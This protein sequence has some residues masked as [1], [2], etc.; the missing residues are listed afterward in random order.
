MYLK[1]LRI[2]SEQPSFGSME[3]PVLDIN[4]VS[5]KT[6]RKR[7]WSGSHMHRSGTQRSICFTYLY[8]WYILKYLDYYDI[9]MIHEVD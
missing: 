7:G 5:K 6:K 9:M 2:S 8:Q 4:R 3:S 1:A